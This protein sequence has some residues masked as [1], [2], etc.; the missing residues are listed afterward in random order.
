MKH[1][2]H[3]AL[4]QFNPALFAGMQDKGGDSWR[5]FRSWLAAPMRVSAIAPSGQSLA[6]LMTSEITPFHGPVLELGPGTGVFT[7]ALL[8]R[9]IA[10]R[11]LTLIEYGAEFIP[12]LQSRFPEAHLH[13]FDATRL[14]DLV[15]AD[16]R[17]QGAVISGLP[18]LSMSENQIHH[19]MSGAFHHLREDG[20]M[21]Q[22]TYGARCPV[23]DAV[24][25]DLGLEAVLIGRTMRNLPPASVYRIQRS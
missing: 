17:K 11:D 20:V 12:A 25:R 3:E 18:L 5:F 23:P 14:H 22:F 15:L 9:G 10:E 16:G 6:R 13:R 7:R 4:S 21:Y 2:V 1:K 19:I 24:L 8:A